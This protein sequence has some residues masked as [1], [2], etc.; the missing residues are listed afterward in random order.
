MLRVILW[1][2]LLAG[3]GAGVGLAIA[4]FTTPI[5]EARYTLLASGGAAD[6]AAARGEVLTMLRSSSLFQHAVDRA[7]QA[8]PELNSKRE[9]ELIPRHD[10]M[11]G[12]G[13]SALEVRVQSPDP[14]IAADVANFIVI[15]YN[16]D[17]KKSNLANTAEKRVQFVR[18]TTTA[19]ARVDSIQKDMEALKL[20]T[21]VNDVNAAIQTAASYE[22]TLTQQSDSDRNQ[23]ESIKK[24]LSAE[25]DKL[26]A[27]SPTTPGAVV[28][29]PDP[30]LEADNKKL[31]E[32]QAQR[33]DLLGTY[34]PTS[35]TVAAVD[36]KIK[37]QQDA[38]ASENLKALKVQRRETQPNPAHLD[39][40]RAIAQDQAQISSLGA[41]LEE[42]GKAQTR[43]KQAV[44][45]L[46]SNEAKML[47]LQR[48]LDLASG[49]YK[50][51]RASSDAL[52]VNGLATQLPI[53]DTFLSAEPPR[54]PVW[55]DSN[56][57]ISVG[58]AIGL[59]LGVMIGASMLTRHEEYE[60]GPQ[61]PAGAALPELPSGISAPPLPARRGDPLAALALPS[62]TPAE[63][64]RFMVFSMLSGGEESTRTVLFTGVSSDSLCSEAAAQFAIA[65][66]QSGVRTLL[67]DCNLRNHGLTEA[68]G[69]KG[70][71]GISDMLS[72]T[73][74]PTAG[75]DL[76]LAT[77]HP[78]LFFMPSGSEEGEGLSGFA[79]L[80]IT[81]LVQELKERAEVKVLNTPACAVVADAPRLVRFA[82]NVCLVASKADRS[83]GLVAKA[84]E[85]L[86]RAGATEVD[87]LV[88]D[89]DE[90]KDSFLG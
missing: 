55:P 28:E 84:H 24:K 3:V 26:A 80:Q 45:R 5:Y 40:E 88:I 39:L 70:K 86:K 18:E 19:K 79:N 22:A 89:R 15:E 11:S 77:E 16:D 58:A 23:L 32:L 20:R 65:M 83:R 66:S 38:I 54:V 25:Q 33:V 53:L 17:A 67:A 73:M 30:K 8:H 63:A 57:M 13:G 29:G 2:A 6:P 37:A 87:V 1:A 71:S 10:A 74:L 31:Q 42:V 51:L 44:R 76:V 82:D 69:F 21:G 7:S 64:Y 43:Q 9:A 34:L 4:K 14:K 61:L 68:F 36:V 41:S 85:I 75:N 81:G 49:R 46:P 59:M 47:D 35:Q 27:T 48:E 60:A 78:D 12:D 52:D 56:L 72:R 62:A 90:S 50:T